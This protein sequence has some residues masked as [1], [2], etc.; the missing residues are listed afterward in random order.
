M[1]LKTDLEHRC[2][3]LGLHDDPETWFA[4][5]SDSNSCH[6]ASP[7][8][9]I[10]RA[11]QVETC[12]SANFVNCPVF[13]ATEGWHGRLP[14]SIR[15]GGKR[16]RKHHTG[17]P[18][19]GARA[20]SPVVA[21]PPDAGHA[22]SVERRKRRRTRTSAGP[23]QPVLIIGAAAVVIITLVAFSIFLALPIIRGDLGM[24]A[25][26]TA[27]ATGAPIA[28]PPTLTPAILTTPTTALPVNTLPPPA[29]PTLTVPSVTRTPTPTN[30]APPT[31]T[32]TQAVSPEP[33]GGSTYIVQRG[34]NLYRIAL[35]YGL[36]VDAILR[37]NNLSN[38]NLIHAGQSIILPGVETAAPESSTPGGT[39][40]TAPGATTTHVVQPGEN[41]FRIALR[42]STTVDV[43]AAY[44]GITDPRRIEPGQ[45]LIVPST[46][47]T[48]Q[49]AP[50]GGAPVVASPE[51]ITVQIGEPLYAGDGRVAEVPIT[52]S[53]Q[54]LTPAVA[55][56]RYYLATNPDGG[57]RWITLLRAAH[58][59]APVPILGEPAPLWRAAVTL[60]DGT[61][62]DAYAG[63]IYEEQILTE[64]GASG[65]VTVILEGGWFDCGSAYQVKPEDLTPGQS[66]TVPLTVYLVHP[67][68]ADPATRRIRRIELEL[69]R[70]DGVS[71]GIVAA[72]EY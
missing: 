13:Q 51:G 11:H 4:F 46:G 63:C 70:S 49:T 6:R 27:T 55:G 66:A 34:D 43:L 16:R 64:S 52:V 44:N 22:P 47:A 8:E 72:R 24:G 61:T 67:R 2:P 65:Q 5:A 62:F 54:R 19:S 41:L 23:R 58:Q 3:Y 30:T 37:A 40:T 18:D 33:T 45:T 60:T 31:P 7:P 25:L 35:R 50:T 10:S 53:N 26:P 28:Q 20:A 59:E 56:G 9:A 38:P 48:G 69:W 12:L 57:R 14:D 15:R 36:S 39:E 29:Q 21:A 1:E 42:Y 71:L 68:S 17:K 32:A